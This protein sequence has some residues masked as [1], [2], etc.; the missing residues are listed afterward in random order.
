[1]NPFFSFILNCN[2]TTLKPE[3]L[4]VSTLRGKM[5]YLNGAKCDFSSFVML[6]G[7]YFSDLNSDLNTL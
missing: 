6:E 4:P 5:L 3:Y 7:S 1:M 2:V